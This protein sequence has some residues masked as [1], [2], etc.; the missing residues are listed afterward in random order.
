MAGL[1]ALQ[2][3]A[4]SAVCRAFYAQEALRWVRAAARALAPQLCT[5]F[6]VCAA[7]CDSIRLNTIFM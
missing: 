5:S 1:A 3:D 4:Y 6:A 2:L 7:H